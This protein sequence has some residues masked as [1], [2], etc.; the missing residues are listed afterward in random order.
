MVL[1]VLAVGVT[2]MKKISLFLILLCSIQLVGAKERYAYHAMQYIEGDDR[3]KVLDQSLS[4]ETDID[5][6]NEL[7]INAGYDAISGA[8]P[9]Y[10]SQ[11]PIYTSLDAA[12]RLAKVKNAQ[13]L[14]SNLLL[15][16]DINSQYAVKKVE[17][18]DNRTSASASWLHR[19]TQRNEWRGGVAYSKEEDYISQTINFSHLNWQDERKNRSYVGAGAVTLNET[20][21]FKTGYQ[22]KAKKTNIVLNGQL[23]IN[24]VMSKNAYVNASL[25]ANF[26]KGYLDNHYQTVL[27][28]IDVNGDN[29]F[30]PNELFLAAETRPNKRIGG[31][32][33]VLYAQR[34]NNYLQQKLRYRFYADDWRLSSHTLDAG[35][36]LSLSEHI[37]IL[38]DYRFYQQNAAKFYKDAKKNLSYFNAQQFASNDERLGQFTAN[39]IELGLQ[40]KLYQNWYLNAS[41]SKYK[42][43]N[44]F[45]ANWYVLGI[46][47]K[48]L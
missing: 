48:S 37:S 44:G 3:V 38:L 25:Y 24:Q 10:T 21:S 34:W 46:S 12:Q 39:D 47:Y 42:Q 22:G 13:S 29:N 6:D 15:G 17:L 2:K 1:V 26:S 27:R 11:T 41:A 45:S 7:S 43:S 19:D 16:Y 28:I 8:S 35:I 31:G 32:F 30:T 36:T 14:S 33:S 5:E 9:T 23:S 18:E 40:F 4:I 20:T